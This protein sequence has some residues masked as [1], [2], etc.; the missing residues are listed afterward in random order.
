MIPDLVAKQLAFTEEEMVK[1]GMPQAAIDAGMAIQAKIMKPAIIAP[2]SILGKYV[3]GNNCISYY[4]YF[5]QERGK[6]SD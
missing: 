6:S 4:K 3:L 2:L 5:H 1:R